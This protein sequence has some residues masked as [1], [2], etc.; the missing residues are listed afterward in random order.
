[1]THL[2]IVC[3]RQRKKVVRSTVLANKYPHN[4]VVSAMALDPG[5]AESGN[6]LVNVTLYANL[7]RAPVSTRELCNRTVHDNLTFVQNDHPVAR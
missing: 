4:V 1:M 3:D 2:H 6:K 5:G 7:E